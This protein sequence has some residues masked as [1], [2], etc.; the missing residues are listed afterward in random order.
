MT[1]SSDGHKPRAASRLGQIAPSF[2]LPN[3]VNGDTVSLAD[4]DGKDVL[5]VFLRGTWCPYCILQLN[6]LR[7]N[8]ALLQ[9][10]NIA[11]VALICQSQFTVR[12][13]LK[14]N[15]LPFPLLCDGSRAI[16]RAYGTHYWLSHEGFNLSHP[17]LF[18]LDQ[19]HSITFAHIGRSMSDLP[20][21]AI[22]DKFLAFLSDK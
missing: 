15:P 11:V 1:I 9:K 13:F 20:V 10:A 19:K 14:T 18:I 12:Q 16:A 6:V 22:L 3:P 4:F 8:F 17:A 2:T 7:E 5:L 21:S